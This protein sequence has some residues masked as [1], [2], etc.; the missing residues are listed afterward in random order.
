MLYT[1]IDNVTHPALTDKLVHSVKESFESLPQLSLSTNKFEERVTAVSSYYNHHKPELSA[2]AEV[3][4]NIDRRYTTA[5]ST[6]I[7][8][9]H[10]GDSIDMELYI[11]I[12]TLNASKPVIGQYPPT[13]EKFLYNTDEHKYVKTTMQYVYANIECPKSSS[14]IWDGSY[15]R[16][17]DVLGNTVSSDS[18]LE[19]VRS[20]VK[21][22]LENPTLTPY[23]IVY[24][25]SGGAGVT[26]NIPNL[27]IYQDRYRLEL[28]EFIEKNYNSQG[29]PSRLKGQAEVDLV[30]GEGSYSKSYVVAVL[31]GIYFDHW[32]NLIVLSNNV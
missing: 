14:K 29:I 21:D 5:S 4:Y 2:A 16:C 1:P 3:Y 28:R 19:V 7:L 31:D 6:P 24:L 9:R 10:N 25:S 26:S 13:T 23:D 32:A 30:V 12:Y 18:R 15:T 27:N 11:D 20:Q 8:L 17:V 22:I